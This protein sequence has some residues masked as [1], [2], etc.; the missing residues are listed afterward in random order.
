MSACPE[1]EKLPRHIAKQCGELQAFL[2]RAYSSLAVSER[3]YPTTLF[4]HNIFWS[5]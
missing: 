2:R 4:V 5:I 1:S 3:F